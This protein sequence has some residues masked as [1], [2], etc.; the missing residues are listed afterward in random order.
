V[1]V[2][3]DSAVARGQRPIGEIL[4]NPVLIGLLIAA[5]IAIPIAVHNRSGS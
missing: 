1:L 3:A 2:V 5:A 4:C